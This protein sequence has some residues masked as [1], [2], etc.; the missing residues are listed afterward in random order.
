MS[1]SNRAT[2]GHRF[3]FH[4]SE[5]CASERHHIVGEPG[6]TPY[7]PLPPLC[8]PPPHVH[9][10]TG[11]SV[12]PPIHSSESDYVPDQLPTPPAD[13]N[14]DERMFDFLVN[15]RSRTSSPPDSPTIGRLSSPSLSPARGY[16][17]PPHVQFASA[18]FAYRP[19]TPVFVKMK[20]GEVLHWHHLTKH[21]EIPAVEDDERAR[22]RQYSQDGRKRITIKDEEYMQEG[23]VNLGGVPVICG[24]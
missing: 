3:V 1:A 24:R 6:V 17:P 7:H 5:I 11:Y 23:G 13:A 4:S 12:H 19:Q 2:N 22:G 21:G 10:N 18:G 9:P 15:G 16:S 8:P 14:N 20:P